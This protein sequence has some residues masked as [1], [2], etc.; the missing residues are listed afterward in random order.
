MTETNPYA[1]PQA[2]LLDSAVPEDLEVA[3]ALWNPNAAGGWSLLLTP[4][5]GAYLH[6]KNWEALGHPDK[7]AT[8][9]KWVIGSAL[10]LVGL[11]IVSVLAPESQDSL[12]N[13]IS[14]PA[15]LGLI[16]AWYYSIGKSQQT[17][18]AERFGKDY[19]RRG[20]IVPILISLGVMLGILAAM[21]VGLVL[22]DAV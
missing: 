6:M 2:E 3:P 11:M 20:W 1:P 4:V 15:G 14:R 18:V 5:F 8:S 17:Y 12:M 22:L 16:L 13:A 9:K 19:P 7:A 10:A 21:V